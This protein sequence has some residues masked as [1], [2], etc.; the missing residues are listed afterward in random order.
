VGNSGVP[1]EKYS[2]SR[3]VADEAPGVLD[4]E[5][6]VTAPG[7]AVTLS[8]DA[9]RYVGTVDADGYLV[10]PQLHLDQGT[11][12]ARLL[13]T[14]RARISAF[15]VGGTFGR[16]LTVEVVLNQDTPRTRSLGFLEGHYGT[17]SDDWQE[18][19]LEVD[20][21]D[22]RFPTDP[23]PGQTSGSSCGQDIEAVPNELTF[24][25]TGINFPAAM[26]ADWLMLE[27][28]D[29]P[30]LA[31]RPVLLVHGLGTS[32]AKMA[33]GT[34]WFNGLQRRDVACQPPDF[35][36]RGSIVNNG[37]E[38]TLAVDDL[39][40]RFGVERVHILAHSSGGIH[41]REHVRA[42]DDV[43]T[44][45]TLGT[46]HAGSFI[47]DCFAPLGDQVAGEL[48]ASIVDI[49]GFPQMMSSA[50]AVYNQSYVRNQK[51][52]F[53]FVAADF[54]SAWAQFFARSFGPND[55]VVS[56]ASAQALS[57]AVASTYVNSV[58]DLLSNSICLLLTN[59][60]CLR[61]YRE[62][63]DDLFPDHLA[64]LSPPPA[65]APTPRTAVGAVAGTA[66]VMTAAG[67]VAPGAT[68]SHSAVVD[69]VDAATFLLLGDPVELRFELVSPAGTR[70]DAVTA[71]PAVTYVAYQ[72][73]GFAPHGGYQ[74]ERPEVGTW[75]LEVT[76]TDAA[77]PDGTGYAVAATLLPPQTGGVVLTVAADQDLYAAGDPV[78]ITATITADGVPV[79]DATAGA[80]VGHPDGSTMIELPLDGT[81]GTYTGA[82][83]TTDAG[84]YVV[85]VSAA[86]PAFARE[87]VLFASVARG[88][89]T[90]AGPISDHGVDT[91]GD[92]LV[93]ELVVEVPVDV[94][95]AGA[96]R[97]FGTLGDGAGTAIEQVRVELDLLP[98][99]QTVSL[100]F[101]GALL[102]GLGGDGPYL[103]EDLVL[104]EI[105]TAICLGQ[106]ESYTTAVYP[107]ADLQ[108]PPCL[109]TGAADDHGLRADGTAQVPYETLVVEVEVD[110]IAG[111]T[112]RAR[113]NIYAEDGT[114]VA[115]AAAFAVLSPGLDMLELRFAARDIFAG[116]R[117]GPYELRQLS[118]WG[119][120]AGAP[121][122]LRVP[123]VVAVTAPYA[124]SDFGEPTR[125]TLGGTVSGLV[126]TDLVVSESLSFLDLHPGNGPFAFTLPMAVGTRYDVR[127][128][129]QPANPSQ[130][131]TVG[132]ATGTIGGGDVTDVAVTCAPP[133][134]QVGLDTDFGSGGTVTADRAGPSA[135]ALQSD[136]GIVLVG[137]RTLS[138]FTGDGLPDLTFGSGGAAT[139]VFSGSG[140]DQARGVAVQPDGLIV[141]AGHTRA[142][143]ALERHLADGSMDLTFGTRGVVITDF[144][145]GVD[146]GQVVL[147]QPDGLIVVAGH[148]SSG[149]PVPA[150]LFAVARYT[151]AGVLDNGFGDH[152]KVTTRIAGGSDLGTAAL[153]QPDG[154]IVV[155]GRV[156]VTGG[157]DPDFG[158]VRYTA[159][160]APDAAFGI[161][162]IVRTD[163]GLDGWVEPTDL[164]LQSD[165]RLVVV[166]RVLLGAAP[167]P[168][169]M[170][171]FDG[172]GTV[173][174]GFGSAGLVTTT[175]GTRDAVARAVAVQAD[176]KIVVAG[177]TGDGTRDEFTIA[178]YT[179]DGVL[180]PGFGTGGTLTVAYFGGSDR[181]EC[182]AVQA[183][184][185]IV[186]AG[187]AVNVR[188][189]KHALARILS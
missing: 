131:C 177:Y 33:E 47:A 11:L 37:A 84:R 150:N 15:E 116:G 120:A 10:D 182:V 147:I 123:G 14:V 138:R 110:S 32:G 99:P 98:G 101:D 59:H 181:A 178:R 25:F 173:D 164:A 44:L 143:F 82:F 157:D 171:R 87:Q 148:A 80:I 46:P 106:A 189:G 118:M 166:G 38:I 186:V 93:D 2:E 12:A 45:I 8:I 24:V 54:N 76:G 17:T 58:D 125:F 42:H 117:S 21:A 160:G 73:D 30:G 188:S 134:A 77:E 70:I 130:L 29:A 151:E 79:T 127:V 119:T 128:T 66:G 51:T 114:F 167:E 56:V 139:V 104:E 174:T 158:V 91:D 5:H 94:A 95:V 180:D 179:A 144:A 105:A 115:S 28:M 71:D 36:P 69:A 121:M 41:A 16:E 163:F 122:S 172:N 13:L 39:K 107:H 1:P 126:G 112:V 4:V 72:D 156:A 141:V 149:P 49:L 89:T 88:G 124:V 155:A 92:G 96:Y 19:V 7:Q 85:V 176:D 68:T 81:D 97:L 168:F 63:V 55:G 75:T 132:N 40:R 60:S 48:G 187:S 62:I 170:A 86:G 169:A 43:E 135:I 67:L 154:R 185:K 9:T 3:F 23:C 53:V 52:S 65:L 6:L 22:V 90:F 102:F 83:T 26:E 152:G 133:P 142:D 161:E 34:A 78:T 100:S 109:L 50:M 175:F 136:G 183:D 103:I 145:A 111:A 20:T 184:D 35:T 64:V 18:F 129:K 27:P 113:A 165:G 137:G 159:K 140:L 162:G 146:Q 61:Y 57:Y 31:W 74:V 108:R 153:L